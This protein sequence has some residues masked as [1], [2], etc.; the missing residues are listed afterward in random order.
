GLGVGISSGANFLGALLVQDGLGPDAI[1]ATVFPD[2]NRKYLTTDLSGNE[3][4]RDGFASPEVEL[5]S[6]D[7]IRRS[8]R[9]C[10]DLEECQPALM[11]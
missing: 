3:P 8:C 7:T 5:L 1:V 2:D 10:E 9:W 11:L 4:Q 6:Y